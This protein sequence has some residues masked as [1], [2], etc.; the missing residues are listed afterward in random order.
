MVHLF[1]LH[2]PQALSQ[3]HIR[4]YDPAIEQ[5]ILLQVEK[6]EN[7]NTFCFCISLFDFQFGHFLFFENSLT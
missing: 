1:L 6:F 3:S 5:R 7:L 2:D 4:D